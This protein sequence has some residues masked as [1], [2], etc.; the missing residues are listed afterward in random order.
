MNNATE[1]PTARI[2]LSDAF[3]VIPA[4]DS[5]HAARI[6]SDVRA[7]KL[8]YM[9][10]LRRTETATETDGMLFVLILGISADAARALG[11]KHAKAV[12]VKDGA[13]CRVICTQ[14]F[15]DGEHAFTEGDV[16]RTIAL[17]GDT[18]FTEQDAAAVF[19]ESI[20]RFQEARSASSLL[21]LIE[22]PR[23]SYFGEGVRFTRVF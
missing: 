23:A 17:R 16:I 1:A 13:D 22:A 10:I 4:C 2:P 12:T 18:H 19:S 6:V 3:A 5:A 15:T 7:A 8:G 14:A 20:D 9:Q 11:A 21:F